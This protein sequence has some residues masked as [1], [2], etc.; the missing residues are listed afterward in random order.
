MHEYN[1][2]LTWILYAATAVGAGG[3]YFNL[4]PLQIAG[5]LVIGIHFY[6]AIFQTVAITREIRAAKR[7]GLLEFKGD[8]H[9]FANPL[10]YYVAKY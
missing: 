2:L 6:I 1:T 7:A 4:L 9:S 3:F 8:K 10:C 5:G